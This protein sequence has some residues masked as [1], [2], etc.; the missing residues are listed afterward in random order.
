MRLYKDPAAEGFVP[1]KGW[2]KY[3]WISKDAAVLRADPWQKLVTPTLVQGR[4]VVSLSYQDY[5]TGQR[6][7]VR[8]SLALLMAETFLEPPTEHGYRLAHIDSNPT[9]CTLSNL[10]YKASKAFVGGPHGR[11]STVMPLRRG[12]AQPTPSAPP[13]VLTPKAQLEAALGF[14]ENA[15]RDTLVKLR[16][17]ALQLLADLDFADERAARARAAAEAEARIPVYK[18]PAP[19]T[20]DVKA[21]PPD[22]QKLLDQWGGDDDG[23]PKKDLHDTIRELSNA[24]PAPKPTYVE[25]QR[26]SAPPAKFS[27]PTFKQSLHY[28][29]ILGPEDIPPEDLLPTK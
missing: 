6:V 3:Y 2:E 9:N 11:P 13:A 1:L 14:M 20:L 22:M 4:P 27:G 29:K 25:P 16:D 5:D 21:L 10:V 17:H 18:P 28:D 8:K 23:K 26:S 19:G 24:P 12:D 7:A 15:D